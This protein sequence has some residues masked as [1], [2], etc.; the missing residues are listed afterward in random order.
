MAFPMSI[1]A[2]SSYSFAIQYLPQTLGTRTAAIVVSN[3]DA[4]ESSYSYMITAKAL[5]D[6]GIRSASN[7]QFAVSIFPNPAQE[8]AILHISSETASDA[9]I[10][11]ISLDGKTLVNESVK[12]SAG[13]SQ[14][15]LSTENLANGVYFVNIKTAQASSQ[16][17]LVINK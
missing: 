14:V 13:N 8:Q 4:D 16:V 17:K 7:S 15:K 6:V 3:D 12:L 9:A 10:S 1:A 11:V 2:G 5:M